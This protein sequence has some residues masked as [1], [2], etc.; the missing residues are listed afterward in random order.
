[1]AASTNSLTANV[2]PFDA[3]APVTAAAFVG[4]APALALGDGCVLLGAPGEAKRIAAHPGAGILIAAQAGKSKLVTGG[5]D[6]RVVVTAGDGS[7]E[8]IAHEKGRWIDALAA[9][10]DGAMAWA[11]GKDV[12]ARDAKGE[13]KTFAAPT[14]VRGLV[15]FPKGYRLALAHYNGVTLWFPNAPASLE[16]LEWKGS[17]LDVTVSPDARFVVTSMQEN[18]LHGWRMA[19]KKDM[20]LSG[21]PAKTRSV[22]WSFDGAW[23]ATSGAE[24]G[25]VWPFKDKEG[26]MNKAPKECGV[27]RARITCVSFHPKALVLALGYE[28]G[29]V[30]LCRITDAA[31][32]LVRGH[33]EGAQAAITALAWDGAGRRL[34]FGAVDGAAGLLDMPAQ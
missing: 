1:M 16:R 29:F 19:D 26:P 15:F 34:L 12:R 30:L 21:Y 22:S 24:G 25:V 11:A 20:R 7:V 8:E 33:R 10:D 18:A 5:D 4:D 27:R 14:T 13:I 28:D 32:I 23:L 31:E 2:T 3:G 17:H 6:G 9:R